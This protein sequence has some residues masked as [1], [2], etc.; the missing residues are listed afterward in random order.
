METAYSGSAW[1]RRFQ[2]P[3]SGCGAALSFVPAA[4]GRSSS[5]T[6][7]HKLRHAH[8]VHARSAGTTQL[9]SPLVAE[10][11]DTVLSV[12]RWR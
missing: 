6:T 9:L 4:R 5:Q 12:R 3:P 2:R 1:Q 8:G 7:G 10:M 11:E